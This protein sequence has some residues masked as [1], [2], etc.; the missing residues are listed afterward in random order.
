MGKG[1]AFAGEANRPSAIYYNPAGLTQ[2]KDDLYATIGFSVLQPLV[3]HSNNSGEGTEMKRQTFVIP[4]VYLV[5]DLGLER[6]TF[7]LGGTSAWGLGT[8]WAD[9]SFSKYVATKSDLVHLDPMLTMAYK[10][11]EKLSLGVAFDVDL[12]KANRKKKLAQSGGADADFQLKGESEGWGYRLSTL[13]E[14]NEQHQFGL[15]YRSPIRHKYRGD[16]YLSDL[17][18]A[19]LNYLAIFG[20]A[21][22]DT[23]MTLELTLPQSIIAGY[24]FRPNDKWVF[25]VDVEWMDWA[26]IEQDLLIYEDETNATRLAILNSGN[27]TAR[28]WDAVFSFALGT[29]YQMNDKLALRAGYYHHQTPISEDNFES[30]LTDAD[31]HGLTAGVGYALNEDL[32]VD[33]AY[34]ALLFEERQIN[35]EVGNSNGANIDGN[36]NQIIHLYL[37]SLTHKF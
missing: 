14:L 8:H 13:Y 37:V 27:P 11:T 26:S 19:G 5:S 23:P 10:M 12:A 28:D 18:A 3:S 25:N 15:M 36:Y 33:L 2:L 24:S 20:A 16:V 17:N 9:D 34:S 6:F 1:S 4:H 30:N 31:S 7:G 29:E 22:Y 21:T 32:M 35:N